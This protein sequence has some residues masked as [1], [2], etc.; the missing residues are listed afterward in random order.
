MPGEAKFAAHPK[1]LIILGSGDG[2]Y[3]GWE[4]RVAKSLQADGYAMVGLDCA[5]YAKTDYDLATLQADMATIAR[6]I[7]VRFGNPAPPLIIGGW[8][9]GAVQAVAAGGGP[10]PPP[11]LA[12]L[13]V[14]SPG[15]RGRYGLRDTDRWDI[16]PTGNGT[17]ALTDFST[18]LGQIRV[19]QWDGK[20]DLLDS[21]RWLDTLTAPHRAFS[22]TFGLHDYNGASDDFL[23]AL[24]QSI[25]W[26]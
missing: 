24:R 26:I 1:A 12:G 16:P 11:G 8:S 20:L 6:T 23:I 2:G 25:E 10:Q 5:N 13:L 18:T 3:G 22:Y 17:F 14:I 19:A 21:T 15:G 7:D 4:E 9:M